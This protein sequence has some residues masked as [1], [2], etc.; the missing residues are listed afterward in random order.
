MEFI[1]IRPHV[2]ARMDPLFANA[3]QAILPCG[4]TGYGFSVIWCHEGSRF[5]GN[6]QPGHGIYCG[7]DTYEICLVK[8]GESEWD[9]EHI[10][11]EEING[12]DNVRGWLPIEEIGKLAERIAAEGISAWWR[13]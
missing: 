9:H 7:N 5:G 13:D 4:D 12:H 6:G 8:L 3:K 1:A 10:S 11:R 2:A